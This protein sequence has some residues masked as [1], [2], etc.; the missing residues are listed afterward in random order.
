M[1]GKESRDLLF[2]RLGGMEERS[3]GVE[4]KVP[5]ASSSASSHSPFLHHLP[6]RGTPLLIAL[7]CHVRRLEVACPRRAWVFTMDGEEETRTSDSVELARRRRSSRDFTV[8]SAARQAEKSETAEEDKA[9]RDVL[10]LPE[11]PAD[12]SIRNLVV[13]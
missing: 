10:P 12:F 2:S 11:V 3:G 13:L 6:V 4:T 5:A 7:S 1:S 9:C 8:S